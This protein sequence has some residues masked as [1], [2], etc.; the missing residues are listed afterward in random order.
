MMLEVRDTI[1]RVLDNTTVDEMRRNA[2]LGVPAMMYH[3]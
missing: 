1:A 3:I 2:D